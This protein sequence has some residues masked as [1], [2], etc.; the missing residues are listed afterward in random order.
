MML[1]VLLLQLLPPGAA[2][3]SST[4]PRQ[5]ARDVSDKSTILH[6]LVDDLGYADLPRP[7]GLTWILG[8]PPEGYLRGADS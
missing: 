5:Q 1:P 7:L 2:G 8:G 6:L 3:G 4:P